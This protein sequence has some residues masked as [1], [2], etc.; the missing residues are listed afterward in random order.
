MKNLKTMINIQADKEVVWQLLTDFAKYPQWNSFFKSIEGEAKVG[1]KLLVKIFA[2]DQ[3][4]LTFK[5]TVLMAKQG[6]QLAWL[7]R[8][9]IPGLFDGEHSFEIKSLEG[10][11]V[12]FFHQEKFSGLLVPLFWGKLKRETLPG[13]QRFNQ[14]L[15]FAA[16][17]HM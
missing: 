8:L 12:R 10:G 14:E 1:E 17:A 16:E 7:G 5:P 4:L 3:S 13:F 6:Q 15:K 11:G 2:K 9:L